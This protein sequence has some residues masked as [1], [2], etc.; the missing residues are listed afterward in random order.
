[1]TSKYE[2]LKKEVFELEK[3]GKELYVSMINECETIDDEN[4]TALKMM[5]YA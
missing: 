2:A 5:A 4:M 1:M 3:R